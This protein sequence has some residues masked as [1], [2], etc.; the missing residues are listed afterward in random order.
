MRTEDFHIGDRVVCVDDTA[1]LVDHNS[2]ITL[3]MTGT[4]RA[5]GRFSDV[6]VGVEWDEDVRGHNLDGSLDILSRRGYFVKPEA[7]A[8]FDDTLESFDARTEI[9]DLL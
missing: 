9:T 5:F 2:A 1:V 3:G 4:V 6:P 7:L 8:I